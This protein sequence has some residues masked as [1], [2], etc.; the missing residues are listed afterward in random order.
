LFVYIRAV[1]R[2]SMTT[3]QRAWW[4]TVL[5]V[6]A[7]TVALS[8]VHGQ[9]GFGHPGYPASQPGMMYQGVYAAAVGQAPAAQMGLNHPGYPAPQPG[10]MYQNGPPIGQAQAIYA[11]GPG[12]ATPAV[13]FGSQPPA[14]VLPAFYQ[15]PPV[16]EE[17]EAPESAP[18]DGY[19]GDG[20]LWNG[21]RR[22]RYMLANI[23]GMLAP[24]GEGGCCAPHWFD[25]HAEFVYLGLDNNGPLIE[26]SRDTGGIT[27]IT[28]ADLDHGKE[29][30][31]RVTG[32]YQT[33]P[34]SNLEFTY[35]GMF[36]FK[37]TR[38]ATGTDELN[39]IFTNFT[40]ND[41]AFQGQEQFD[42]ADL[43]QITLA[44][45]FDSLEL[46][47]RRRWLGPT[48]L[49]QGS[50]M[51]GVRYAK[52][53]ET[54]RFYSEASRDTDGDLVDDTGGEGYCFVDATN[55]MTGPQVGGDIWMCLLPGLNLGLDVKLAVLGNNAKQHTSIYG[56]DS[57]QAPPF[58]GVVPPE[59]IGNDKVS[60]L[61]ELSLNLRYRINHRLTFR[62]GYE[63]VMVEGVALALENFNPDVPLF[64][65][66]RTPAFSDGGALFYNGIT[67]GGEWMW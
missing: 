31:F 8:D 16:P 7:S 20:V 38:T 40:A 25:I 35:L 6:A 9:T 32:A 55:Y 64:G 14:G 21:A 27:R 50:W 58:V 44:N 15:E 57:F 45:D 59:T 60:F 51:I 61:G 52:V 42:Q 46:N 2:L 12:M 5:V 28:S 3:I 24:Y 37:Q 29:A 53:E 47:Y 39:S 48:C 10:M 19:Y 33:G 22:S 1:E 54:L 65:V 62:A 67:I 34:G 11:P 56:I 43:H 66:T 17:E 4:T 18:E 36:D 41:P 26:F 49:L 63:M 23:L 30:G 13:S